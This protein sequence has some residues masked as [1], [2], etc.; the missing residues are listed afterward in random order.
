MNERVSAPLP[1]PSLSD[2]QTFSDEEQQALVEL[3]E[4]YGRGLDLLSPEE[5]ARLRFLRWLITTGRMQ[6]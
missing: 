5:R 3:R 4:S 1:D 2:L 6:L